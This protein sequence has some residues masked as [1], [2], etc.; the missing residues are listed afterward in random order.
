MGNDV[1]KKSERPPG[2]WT[3]MV[4]MSRSRLFYNDVGVKQAILVATNNLF[5][6]I[7]CMSENS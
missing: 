3:E 4:K 7:N 6:I 2:N 1:F 5:T